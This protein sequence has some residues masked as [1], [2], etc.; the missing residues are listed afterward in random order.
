M[1]MFHLLKPAVVSCISLMLILPASVTS[2][3]VVSNCNLHGWVASSTPASSSSFFPSGPDLP[4]LPSGSAELFVHNGNSQG[5]QLITNGYAGTQLSALD[6][7]KYSTYIQDF[8]SGAMQADGI[9][10][11]LFVDYNGDGTTDDKLFFQ[12]YFQL[13]SPLTFGVWQQW[14]A[15][16]GGWW[17]ANGTANATPGAGIKPLSAIITA[18]PAAKIVSVGLGAGYVAGTW[19]N[20]LGNADAFIIRIGTGISTMFNFENQNDTDND[21]ICDDVDLCPE[22]PGNGAEYYQDADHDGYGN[23]DISIIACQK[24]QGY[25][26]NTTDCDD[27]NP[28]VHPGAVEICNNIDDDCD[29]LTDEGGPTVDAGPN[30]TVYYAGVGVTVPGYATCATLTASASGGFGRITYLWDNGSTSKSITVC[31]SSTSTYSVTVTDQHNCN[32]SDNVSVTVINAYC[33]ELPKVDEVLVCRD[34]STTCIKLKDLNKFIHDGYTFGECPPRGGG[35][36]SSGILLYPNPTTGKFSVDL[37]QFKAQK[38]QL[39]IIQNGLGI[40]KHDVLVSAKGQIEMFNLSANQDGIYYLRLISKEG[41]LT[42]KILK[43]R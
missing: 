27:S 24:P 23:K 1:K 32:A 5:A 35:G 14:D 39:Q 20:F 17:S 12:P 43:V 31:P 13:N 16:A 15:L 38:I 11:V 8:G 21:G 6:E 34:H 10:A 4:P 3:T 22:T 30:V 41:V 40:E 36:T 42:T 33:D 26:T 19:A 9:Y 2:Q 37:S 18:R 7:L 29:G 28:N 25:V